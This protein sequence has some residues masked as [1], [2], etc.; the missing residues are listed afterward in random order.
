[1]DSL[2]SLPLRCYIDH[3]VIHISIGQD[4][5]AFAT[6]HHPAFDRDGEGKSITIMDAQILALDVVR[7]I[8]DE[9]E[10]GSTL[11]TRMLDSAILNVIGNGTEGIKVEGE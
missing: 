7:E 2:E 1:M 4:I 8:N 6:V 10:D 9:G 3:G 11:L 5:L